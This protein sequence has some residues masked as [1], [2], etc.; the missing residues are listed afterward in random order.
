MKLKKILAFALALCLSVT[1]FTGCGTGSSSSSAAGDT[2]K[3]E[4]STATESS[5]TESA[6]EQPATGATGMYPGTPEANSLTLNLSTEPPELNTLTSTYSISFSVIRSLYEN[7]VMLDKDDNVIPGVAESWEISP[8]GLSY[9]FKLREGMK[10][11]N[12]EPV[13]AND[14]V[15]AWKTLLDPAT[16][17]EYAYFAYIFKNGEAYYDYLSEKS[18][19]ESY[20]KD[21]EAWKTANPDKEEPSEAKLPKE[22]K[23]EDLG[24]KANSDYELEVTLE[25]PTAYALF[26]FSF[27]SLAPV[28]EKFYTKVGADNYATDPEFF[29]TNGAFKMESW[30]HESN[31]VMVKNPDFYKASDVSLEKITWA[32]INETNAALN[33]FKAN[34][35]DMISLSGDQIVQMKNENYPTI[36]YSDGSEFHVLM[37]NKDKYLSNVNLRRAIHY[38]YDREAYV[39]AILKDNS[40]TAESFTIFAVAGSKGTPFS[41]DV[42]AANG[43]TPLVPKNA[44]AA[45]AKEYLE[46]ALKEL[47]VT[48]ED[49]NKHLSM[50]CGD[51]DIATQQAAFFQEQLRTNLGIEIQ[52]KSMTTKAQSQER[53]NRNYVMDFTGWGPDYNDPMTFLDMWVTGGGNNSVDFSNA[54]Y[55]EL[56]KLA[57]AETDAEK[58][59][60]Y[61]IECEQIIADQVPISATYWRNRTY[62]VS[63][64]LAG[65]YWRTAFQDINFTYA[66]VK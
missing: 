4:E 59:Q 10:W 16:A 66:T 5:A 47:N 27:G 38:A 58:R 53:V 34:E 46:T 8:D 51:S 36:D 43:G 17:S 11:T 55:D 33:S 40:L 2:S 19:L 18:S 9:K 6:E 13:T 23:V 54:R 26:L 29:C 52:I 49:L 37:N 20:T 50:N 42:K 44:D 45:K 63:E 30:T 7:L 48:V 62:V 15:F 3:A 31:I 64:K 12:G 41:D 57:A 22:V 32:M 1:A 21:A 39:K 65:N 24:F 28:N 56:I 35:V 60:E 61:F 25:N 14:F